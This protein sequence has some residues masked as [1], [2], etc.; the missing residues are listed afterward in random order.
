MARSP[1]HQARAE[2]F[3]EKVKAHTARLST[4]RTNNQLPG[5][6]PIPD[7]LMTLQPT[8]RDLAVALS[9]RN[10]DQRARIAPK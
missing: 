5:D 4:S 10:S 1:F 2:E 8:R 9:R 6:V 7:K 3:A